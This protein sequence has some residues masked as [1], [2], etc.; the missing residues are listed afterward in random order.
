M[1]SKSQRKCRPLV[2]HLSRTRSRLQLCWNRKS[3]LSSA[4]RWVCWK[5]VEESHSPVPELHS[6]NVL[7]SRQLRMSGG[8]RLQAVW[9]GLKF[10]F[11]QSRLG[12]KQ[13]M[14]GEGGGS[15]LVE[16]FDPTMPKGFASHGP[17]SPE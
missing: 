14:D 6:G 10:D 13:R 11:A 4:Y 15:R 3:T 8:K 1:A 17:G 2:R 16:A 9:A 5:S 12:S 7:R